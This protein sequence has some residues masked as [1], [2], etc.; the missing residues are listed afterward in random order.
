METKAMVTRNL[1]YFFSKLSWRSRMIKTGKNTGKAV[2]IVLSMLA[3]LAM[4]G[5]IPAQTVLADNT[6]TAT[7]AP[8]TSKSGGATETKIDV[9]DDPI[10]SVAYSGDGK[11]L[12]AGYKNGVS[13]FDAAKLT[14]IKAVDLSF[15][16]NEAVDLVFSPDSKYLAAVGRHWDS[17]ESYTTTAYVWDMTDWSMPFSVEEGR[18]SITGLAWNANS[19]L[20]TI[21]RDKTDDNGNAVFVYSM[22]GAKQESHESPQVS[23]LSVNTAKDDLFLGS[24]DGFLY[25]YNATASQFRSRV[26]F[27]TS[28]IN[29]LAAE[30]SQALLAAGD[31]DGNLMLLD[32]GN[33]YPFLLKEKNVG[34]KSGVS[35]AHDGSEIA[36]CT[37]KGNLALSQ[38]RV[39]EPIK[40]LY[41]G[42]DK[43]SCNV[44][45]FSTDGTTLTAGFTDG[46]LRV[47]P[48]HP[49]DLQSSDPIAP[50]ASV[51]LP[52]PTPNA[53]QTISLD[54]LPT[55]TVPELK[56]GAIVDSNADQIKVLEKDI[57]IEDFASIYQS[58]LTYP[59]EIMGT[60]GNAL[61]AKDR[62]GT[63]R[64]EVVDDSIINILDQNRQIRVS[65]AANGLKLTTLT[66]DPKADRIA[67]GTADGTVFIWNTQTGE[68]TCEIFDTPNKVRALRFNNGGSILAAGYGNMKLSLFS[69]DTCG[70]IVK[71]ADTTKPVNQISFSTDD[72]YLVTA[73]TDTSAQLFKVPTQESMFKLV[74]DFSRN[75]LYTAVYNPD[76]TLLAVGSYEGI[77][78]IW[79]VNSRE[80]RL[81]LT[82]GS[83]DNPI[84]NLLFSTDGT[85]LF[86]CLKDKTCSILGIPEK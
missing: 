9:S 17:S 19:N 67:A 82:V 64:A 38:T 55:Q 18:G 15:S 28:N 58:Q 1:N 31:D 69:P 52:A 77:L 85:K 11:L 56:K 45:T 16:E 43:E 35:I 42:T 14:F 66:F 50:F 8:V 37:S 10:L 83:D 86:A 54:K 32:T 2:L 4:L 65:L 34:Y 40:T 84:T 30:N 68:K 21:T 75:G 44:T 70:R 76:Q 71:L 51:V 63:Y 47:Y 53:G 73:E 80:V 72:V 57:D 3:M 7:P 78:T 79:N 13:L 6:R 12:A 46:A 48:I 24:P 26:K 20:L 60:S 23:R 41:S 49:A 62:T 81:R 29:S 27:H 61:L 59:L 36:Y 39:L 5:L 33:N 25:T 74:P 22:D